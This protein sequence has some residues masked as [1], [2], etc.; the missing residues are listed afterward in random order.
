MT[1]LNVHLRPCSLWMY[2]KQKRLA[3][4]AAAAAQHTW[5]Q[6]PEQRPAGGLLEVCNRA[7]APG[8][9]CATRA[10][11]SLTSAI[12]REERKRGSSGAAHQY[13]FHPRGSRRR[14]VMAEVKD[15]VLAAWCHAGR[16]IGD[17]EGFVYINLPRN[18]FVYMRTTLFIFYI[19]C[20]NKIKSFPKR[21][22]FTLEY[23]RFI[24]I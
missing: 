19:S 5:H 20:G 22:S 13:T 8:G 9:V 6:E 1:P 21:A 16:P 15:R 23:M 7:M 18:D 12:T 3:R 2:I 11:L 10:Q 17:G 14:A 24:L 4:E